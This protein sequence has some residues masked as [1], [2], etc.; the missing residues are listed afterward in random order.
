MNL[1]PEDQYHLLD[2]KIKAV[3]INNLFALAVIEKRIRGQIFVDDVNDP[4][5]FYVV[6]PYNMSLLFGDYSNDIFN[7]QFKTYALNQDRNRNHFVWLQTFPQEWDNVLD[8]LFGDLLIKTEDN[9]NNQTTG[10]IEL[11]NRINFVF[12]EDKPVVHLG[13]I[14][15]DII[16]VS[17]QDKLINCLN[18]G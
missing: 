14:D 1:L 9:V 13:N 4:K 6:H 16:H 18:N 2:Q 11:H 7:Q 3:T 10:V 15:F 5:I 12:N 17:V 8:S